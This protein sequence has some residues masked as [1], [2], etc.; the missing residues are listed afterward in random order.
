MPP[1]KQDMQDRLKLTMI[2]CV[3]PVCL[4]VNN[5]RTSTGLSNPGI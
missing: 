5:E 1:E 3:N 4:E 2:R